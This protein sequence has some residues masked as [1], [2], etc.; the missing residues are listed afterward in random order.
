MGVNR[1]S[2]TLAALSF[3]AGALLA[4]EPATLALPDLSGN[5]QTLE[6]Y[7]GRVVVL[8]FWATWCVPCRAEMPLLVNVQNRYAARGVVVVGASA[9]DEST[10]AQ[11]KPFIEALLITFP[12]WTGATTAHME[13][14]GLGAALPATAIIDEQGQIAFRIIGILERKDL[15]RRID[16]LLS[17]RQGKAPEPLLDTLSTAEQDHKGH[18]HGKEEEHTHGGVGVE[19]ASMVPS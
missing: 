1:C 18:E 16:Y 7:R 11:I 12:I 15:T 14:L 5:P 6:Q 10:Q 2:Q 9:D 8:N 19:G 13:Q 17:G 3:I 4:A